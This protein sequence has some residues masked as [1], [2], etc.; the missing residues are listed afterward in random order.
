MEDL[1]RCGRPSTSIT[2]VNIAKLKDIVKNTHTSLR[3]TAAELFVLHEQICAILNNNLCIKHFATPLVPKDLNFLQKHNYIRVAE[4][5][6]GRVNSGQTYMERIL[7]VTRR[8]FNT[9]LTNQS[10]NFLKLNRNRN[11]TWHSR[12]KLK[13]TLTD[14]FDYCFVHSKFL[15]KGYN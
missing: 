8:V 14:F 6:V 7:Q 15:S 13:V 1:P 2:Q 5:I 4:V 3:K 12:S 11:K 10:T 9:S